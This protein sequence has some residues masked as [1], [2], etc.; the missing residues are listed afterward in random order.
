[1]NKYIIYIQNIFK[2]VWHDIVGFLIPDTSINLF[3]IN[4]DDTIPNTE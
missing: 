2:I 3:T 4:L 1:M